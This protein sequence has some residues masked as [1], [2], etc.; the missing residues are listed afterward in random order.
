M[1]PK[2]WFIDRIGKT[3]K[4]IRTDLNTGKEVTSY[5]YVKSENVALDC[6]FSQDKYNKFS[7]NELYRLGLRKLRDMVE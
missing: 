2:Q 6:Y 7:D 3:L 5:R 4:R 1:H